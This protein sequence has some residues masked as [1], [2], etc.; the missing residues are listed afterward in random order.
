MAFSASS[1]ARA[2]AETMLN[3]NWKDAVVE[4]DRLPKKRALAVAAY[5]AHYLDHDQYAVGRLLRLLSDRL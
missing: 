2:L 1:N 3:G 4:L 5:L